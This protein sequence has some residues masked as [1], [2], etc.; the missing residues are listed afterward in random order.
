LPAHLP[1]KE[2]TREAS[3]VAVE[4]GADQ[5]LFA[6]PNPLSPQAQAVSLN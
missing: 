3:S 2:F 1:G 5:H 6:V 4:P